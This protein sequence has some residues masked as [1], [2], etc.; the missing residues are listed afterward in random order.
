MGEMPD[1][2]AM[3]VPLPS[4]APRQRRTTRPPGERPEIV[5]IAVD[6]SS[7]TPVAVV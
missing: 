3:T 2:T 7:G 6:V 5:V 4:N 1:A